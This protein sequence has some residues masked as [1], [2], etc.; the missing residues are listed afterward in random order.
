[1]SKGKFGIRVVFKSG[2]KDFQWYIEERLR[3]LEYKRYKRSRSVSL[4]RKVNK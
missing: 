4:V 2:R 3:D 1:M